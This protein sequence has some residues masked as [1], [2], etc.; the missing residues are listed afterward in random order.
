MHNVAFQDWFHNGYSNQ[1]LKEIY[2]ELFIRAF[3]EQ[4]KIHQRANRCT[5]ADAIESLLQKHR[6][7]MS[8]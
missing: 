2:T 4:P 6:G 7:L 8:S 5:F 3:G 1:D